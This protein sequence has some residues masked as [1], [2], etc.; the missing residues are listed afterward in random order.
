MPFGAE[1]DAQGQTH[2]RLWAPTAARV[3]LEWSL[4]DRAP[5]SVRMPCDDG[6]Y[7]EV[8]ADA[9]PGTRYRYHI[10]GELFVPD[11]ASR[12][13][14]EDVHGRSEVI[15]PCAYA[16]RDGAWRGRPWQ[17]AVIYELHVGA[18]TRAGTYAAI[19]PR[20]AE[21]ARLGVTAL[22][23]MPVADFPGRRGWGYDGVLPFAP[24][25]AY[26]RP[27]ALKHLVDCAHAAGLMVILDVVYN[28]FGP[29]GAYLHRYARPFFTDRHRTPWGD[30][31]NFDG[32]GSATVREFF[33]QNAL[34]WLE[35]F[36]LDGLRIDAVHAIMDDSPRHFV[37]E[38]AERVRAATG[39]ERHVHLVLENHANE[40]RRLQRDP[41]GRPRQATAQ[42]NDDLHHVLHTLLTGERDG[43]Y[44]DYAADPVRLLGR[45]LAEGF[46]FQGDAYAFEGGRPRG[47]P[48]GDLPADAF[49]AFLQNHD[50]V[51]NRA[52]GERIAT[53]ARPEALRAAFAI[54]LLAPSPPML[55]MGDE[56]AATQPF[57]FF[58]DFGT[59]LA[60]AVTAGRR[61]EFGRFAKF[62]DPAAQARIPDPNA[63]SSFTASRLRW[64]DRKRTPHREWL[65]LVRRL[66]RIR[67]REIVPLLARLQA[68]AARYEVIDGRGLNVS[69]PTRDGRELQL[70]ANPGQQPLAL[71]SRSGRARTL[72][73]SAD[74]GTATAGALAPWEVRW[75]CSAPRRKS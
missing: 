48:S 58:C 75:R 61:R 50:Q 29:E 14:P 38:L 37:A 36:H 15:D 18:F 42:W 23:L 6:W 33:I 3:D 43:Y 68:G 26:G 72:Y 7:R 19:E 59:D 34:Y 20:L 32:P 17:Q 73:C 55:F 67:Q 41:H 13:N 30:A 8:R 31:I 46:A 60:A 35:E 27:E 22:E 4:G 71:G 65:A 74:R 66:L 1:I 69:W 57:L 11:P 24:E 45:C 25:S 49:V 47:E 40:A 16:W 9:P 62:S 5:Q 52:F 2:F 70:L 56:Y 44:V 28:H 64:S 63:A 51:G 54:L 53:L 21:L 12:F 39:P 10:D